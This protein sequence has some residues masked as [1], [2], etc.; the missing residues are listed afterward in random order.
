M[1]T[2]S[3]GLLSDFVDSAS[4]ISAAFPSDTCHSPFQKEKSNHRAGESNPS[5]VPKGPDQEAKSTNL[6]NFPTGL[7]YIGLLHRI[8]NPNLWI[9]RPVLDSPGSHVMSTFSAGWIFPSQQNY[10]VFIV[11]SFCHGQLLVAAPS[12]FLIGLQISEPHGKGPT[13]FHLGMSS[14][15]Y[16]LIHVS[17]HTEPRCSFRVPVT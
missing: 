5:A 10:P 8:W 3:W 1:L 14:T 12:L 11:F 15:G 16:Q 7:L 4:M 17:S 2:D 13:F 9:P 6:Q